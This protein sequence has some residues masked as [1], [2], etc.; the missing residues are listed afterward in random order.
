V[1]ET[2]SKAGK[3]SRWVSSVASSLS[4]NKKR[5]VIHLRPGKKI[6]SQLQHKSIA[7]HSCNWV[8]DN[9]FIGRD[10]GEVVVVRGC[11]GGRGGGKG[12]WLW[13]DGVAVIF[14]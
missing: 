4:S 6:S 5:L 7:L 9:F 12:G 14:P 2:I 11:I 10:M 13:N 8:D 1:S 3:V